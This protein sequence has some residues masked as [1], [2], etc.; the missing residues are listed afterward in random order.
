MAAEKLGVEL[1]ALEVRDPGQL[2]QAFADLISQGVKGLVVFAHAFAGRYR[3]EIV[4]AA[5][6]NQLPAMYGT[7]LYIG[8][9]GLVAYGPSWPAAYYRAAYYVDR[10]LRGTKPAD[11]PVELPMTFDFVVNLKTA[12]ALG[13][14]FPHEIMLQVTDVVQ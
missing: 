7:R 13:I 12:Q 4:A 8:D 14:T 1:R 5:A 2:D 6:N 11:L 10:I 3:R 9:G